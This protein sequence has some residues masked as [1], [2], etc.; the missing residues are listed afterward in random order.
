MTPRRVSLVVLL[1]SLSFAPPVFAQ[2]RDRTDTPCSLR[3]RTEGTCEAAPAQAARDVMPGARAADRD[4]LWEGA[5]LGGAVGA[6]YGVVGALLSEC[7]RR[8][9]RSCAGDRAAL[10]ALS[11]AFGAGVGIAI[12]ALTQPELTGAPLPGPPASERRVGLPPPSSRGAGV[13]F[14]LAW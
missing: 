6:G 10:V 7:P 9:A 8:T 4:P 13:R 1:V 14:R 3:D 11:T 5:L 12:D 2:A